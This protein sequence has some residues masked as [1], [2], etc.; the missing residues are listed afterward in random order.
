MIPRLFPASGRKLK[1][2]TCP[3][4][5][6]PSAG[7]GPSYYARTLQ[8]IAS[9]PQGLLGRSPLTA[10]PGRPCVSD[11]REKPRLAS[12]A[13]YIRRVYIPFKDLISRR[14]WIKIRTSSF[15]ES[16]C[17][18]VRFRAMAGSPIE[19]RQAAASAFERATDALSFNRD[20]STW[21]LPSRRPI[22]SGL[23]LFW[24]ALT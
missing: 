18:I 16:K 24:A 3:K 23:W 9:I 4:S 14:G 19:S 17:I 6:L 20:L 1:F 22:L 12:T 8:F 11:F 7:K 5:I 21:K 13:A 10:A 2:V 15:V